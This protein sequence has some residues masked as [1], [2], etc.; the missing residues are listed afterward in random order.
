M[1]TSQFESPDWPASPEHLSWARQFLKSIGTKADDRPVLIIPDRDVDGLTSGAIIHRLVKRV[2][3]RDRN[4]DVQTRFVA[5]GASIHDTSEK[6]EVDAVNPR[7][8]STAR[9]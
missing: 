8:V 3:L 2:L 7:C 4:I 6:A 9:S 5:K 1:L